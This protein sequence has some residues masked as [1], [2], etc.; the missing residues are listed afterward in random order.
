LKFISEINTSRILIVDAIVKENVVAENLDVSAQ[1]RITGDVT[2]SD[3]SVFSEIEVT[4]TDF[5]AL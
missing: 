1:A 4:T 5:F 3:L 2:V